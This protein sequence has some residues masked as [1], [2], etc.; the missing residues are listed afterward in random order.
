LKDKP[1]SLWRDVQLG[2]A[3]LA[4]PIAWGV[5]IWWQP[6]AWQPSWP[7]SD[8]GRFLMLVAVY[9]VLEE[10]V[11]RGALQGWLRK[12]V[13]GKNGIGPITAANMVTT[14]VFTAL[15]GLMHPPLMAALVLAPSLIFGYFRDRDSRLTIPIALHCFY[16]TGYFWLYGAM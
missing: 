8:P 10:I 5:L 3:I 13:W 14:I 16:N 2:A 12:F 6:P 15:H 7:L 9:P 1:T 11:F 4:A